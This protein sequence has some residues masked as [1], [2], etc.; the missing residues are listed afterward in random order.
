M[1]TPNDPYNNG[2]NPYSQNGNGHEGDTGQP[3]PADQSGYG[4]D[5]NQNQGYGQDYG[6]SANGGYGQ[7]PSQSQGYGYGYGQDQNQGYNQGQDYGQGQAQGANPYGSYESYNTSASQ[8][9]YGSGYVDPNAG[10]QSGQPLVTNA[11]PLPVIE[12][13]TFGFKRVFTSQWHVYMG[14]SVIPM[15]AVM[16]GMA[17]VIAP[18]VAGIMADPENFIVGAGSIASIAV[19]AILGGI[20]SLVFQIVMTKVALRDAAGEAPAWDRAFKDVPWAQGILVHI[21][22][23]LA[24]LLVGLVLMAI[25]LILIVTVSPA[26]G[27][28]LAV[29]VVF[30]FIFL[31]PFIAL[32]PLYAIDGRTSATGAF[33]AA[34]NDVKASYWRVLGA[35]VVVGLISTIAS[36]IT[37]GLSSIIMAPV[38]ALVS[39]FVYRWISDRHE[40]PVQQ[41]GYMSMY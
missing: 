38:T 11:G 18:M 36:S 13:L 23:G 14:L 16:V 15:V 22:V 17:L 9:A 5:P 24:T 25:P 30:G 10:S 7:D 20:A 1:T 34:F 21:L 2:N 12:S 32:I 28:L 27:V 39:V 26:L 29:I 33:S 4:Q 8:D 6:Q 41:D 37:Q 19:L 31:Y 3:G 35:L 40:Q